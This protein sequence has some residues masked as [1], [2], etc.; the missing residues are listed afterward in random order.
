MKTKIVVLSVLVTMFVSVLA[1]ANE[2]GNPKVV[3]VSQKSG[4]FKV[5]YEGEKAGKVTMKIFSTNGREVFSEV[6]RGMTGF[7]RPMN[8][9]G[10]EPGEYTI[11]ITD[12]KGKQIQKIDYRNETSVKSVH[13]TKIAKEGKYLLAIAAKNDTEKINV[14]IFDGSSNLV[15]DE[16]ITI[17]GNFGL[18]YNLKQ[19]A[20]TPTFEITDKT[21]NTEIIK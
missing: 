13:V 19:V 3:V 7:M 4:I 5:I 12:A 2:P 18:V 6:L 16:S 8:F 9:Q 14:R 17:N 11:E 21:G 1:M 20:G 15:H 10:M